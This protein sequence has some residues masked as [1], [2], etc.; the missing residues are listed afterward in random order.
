[1][2]TEELGHDQAQALMRTNNEAAP[3]VLRAMA[4]RAVVE[5]EL[6]RHSLG[7]SPGRWAP[8]ALIAN[9][10][11]TVPGLVMPQGEAS[12]LAVLMVGAR[13]GE[14][15]LDA[16]AAPGGKT[17]YLAS[18][19]GPT[20]SVVAVDPSPGTSRRIGSAV[21]AA[22][23]ANVEIFAGPIAELPSRSPFDRVLVDA[24][25][26]GLGTLR[27]KPEIRWRI[28]AADIVAL[29]AKQAKILESAAPWVKPGGRLVY[30]TCT[31]SERENDR[32]VEDFLVSHTDFTV[33]ETAAL[34]KVLEPLL[35]RRYRLRTFPHRHGTDGFYAVAMDRK[36]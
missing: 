11:L 27:Q 19:V 3:T 32:V 25:C 1:M 15:I 18:L 10:P 23:V 13:R 31:V 36:H 12:Q 9:R 4:D 14:N 17:V 22:R 20:G 21:N 34:D 8:Q 29:A 26:S 24:P 7:F 2:W 30:S 6:K 33:T 35:D 5:A 28:G 16:C